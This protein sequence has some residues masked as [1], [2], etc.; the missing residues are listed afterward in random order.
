MTFGNKFRGAPGQRR[1]CA[2]RSRKLPI[3]RTD[4]DGRDD[5]PTATRSRR[6]LV[7]R[8]RRR[9]MYAVLRREQSYVPRHGG[10]CNDG[11]GVSVFA[12]VVGRRRWR[13]REGGRGG[14]RTVNVA[15]RVP[16]KHRTYRRTYFSQ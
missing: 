5:G 9:H 13:R 4:T 16:L 14:G 1:T 12:R 10:L 6:E 8:N 3:T 7:T 2:V 15:N 11:L